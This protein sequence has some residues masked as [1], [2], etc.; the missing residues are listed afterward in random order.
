VTELSWHSLTWNWLDIVLIIVLSFST[1]RS[2]LKGF[3]REIIGLAAALFALVLGMWFYGLAGSYIAPYV[4]SPRVANLAGFLTVVLS[5][6]LIGVIAAKIVSRFVRSAGL[7]FFDHMLGAAFGFMRG[8]LIAVALL[9]AYIA[10]GPPAEASAT[11]AAVVHS[12]I[13]PWLIEASRYFVAIAPMELKQS[14]RTQYS[15][16]ESAL[17]KSPHNDGTKDF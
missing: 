4:G 11:P 16:I 12:R 10:F 3:S 8:V 1:I 6:L 15:R 5:V 17:Q 13:A 7:S 9:T 14:F 2:F